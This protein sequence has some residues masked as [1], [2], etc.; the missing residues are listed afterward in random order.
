MAGETFICER[1]P[2][3]VICELGRR[4]SPNVGHIAVKRRDRDFETAAREEAAAWFN[5]N[6]TKSQVEVTVVD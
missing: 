4:Y 5:A 3:G 6:P 1:T 2:Q